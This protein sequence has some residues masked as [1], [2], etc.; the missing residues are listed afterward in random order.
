[1]HPA[2]GHHEPILVGRDEPAV[3]D[4]DCSYFEPCATEDFADTVSASGQS[5]LPVSEPMCAVGMELAECI[6]GRPAVPTMCEVDTILRL[7]VL[8]ALWRDMKDTI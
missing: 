7:V 2:G 1:M 4:S 8:T 5:V 3:F 6:T